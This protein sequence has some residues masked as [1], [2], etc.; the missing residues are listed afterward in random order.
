MLTPVEGWDTMRSKHKGAVDMWAMLVG[1]ALALV[2]L[3]LGF[4]FATKSDVLAEAKWWDLMTAFGTVGAT[5]VALVLGLIPILSQARINRRRAGVVVWFVVPWLGRIRAGCELLSQCCKDLLLVP[6]GQVADGNV[7]FMWNLAGP[8][9][10]AKHMF[11]H[12]GDLHLLN[13][14]S[15][16][17]AEIIAESDRLHDLL[18]RVG[19]LAPPLGEERAIF[20]SID[21]SADELRL[22]IEETLGRNWPSS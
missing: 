3:L 5:V 1:A 6:N 16:V 11:Q 22:L 13:E 7:R 14:R 21:K 15:A 12:V 8:L 17:L 20:T 10:N 4:A 18:M 2:G 9:L 19:D